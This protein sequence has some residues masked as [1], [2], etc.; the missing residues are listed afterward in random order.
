MIEHVTE[1]VSDSPGVTGRRISVVSEQE[2]QARFGHRPAVISIHARHHVAELLERALFDEGWNTLLI[3][4]NGSTDSELL[5]VVGALQ[6]AGVIGIF[7][8]TT[9]QQHQ[10]LSELLG[11]TLFEVADS[12]ASDQ[13]LAGQ[14]LEQL[15]FWNRAAGEK[16]GEQR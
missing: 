14:L 5:A 9:K 10:R 13:E 7:T 1:R 15:R 16:K 11:N 3:D 6:F 8:S 4:A 2:R 12:S